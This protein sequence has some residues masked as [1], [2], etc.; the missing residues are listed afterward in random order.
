MKIQHLLLFLLPLVYCNLF[1]QNNTFIIVKAGTSIKESVPAIDVYEYPQFTGGRVFLKNGKSSGAQMNYNRFLDEMQFITIKGDTLTLIDQKNIAF[2][3]I[4]EDTFFY[5]Q[6]YI[7]LLSRAANVK[8]GI[9]Q[10][11]RVM[12]KEK[13]GAYG[14]TSSNDDVVSYNSYNDG[15]KDFRLTVMQDLILAKKVQYFIADNYNHF[16]L[17]TKKNFIKLFPKQEQSINSY[18]KGNTT[19]FNNKENLEKLIQFVGQL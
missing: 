17:A 13:L 19:V 7:K 15:S 11:L 14:M 16:V 12:D 18:L 3:N 1:A 10:I 2:I 9:K 5:D 6:G 8:L 4:A